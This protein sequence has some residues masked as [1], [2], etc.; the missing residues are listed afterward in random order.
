MDRKPWGCFAAL[1]ALFFLA[2]GVFHVIR[3]PEVDFGTPVPSDEA[4]APRALT[5]DDADSFDTDGFERR[6]RDAITHTLALKAT[7]LRRVRY[8]R[9]SGFLDV[10]LYVLCDEESRKGLGRSADVSLRRLHAEDVLALISKLSAMFDAD[11][12]RISVSSF[13]RA[14][15]LSKALDARVF[16]CRYYCREDVPWDDRSKAMEAI[17]AEY[18]RR[19][20]Q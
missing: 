15:D 11:L 19:F 5:F 17:R 3:N 2:L 16:R 6:I 14:A 18:D 9:R 10:E 12:N 7:Q 20:P 8:D 13:V 1:A 4:Q